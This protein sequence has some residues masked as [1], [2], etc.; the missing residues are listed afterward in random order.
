MNPTARTSWLAMIY[1][2]A[3]FTSAFLLFQIQPL[4]GK[5]ILPWFG[6]SPAVWT[7]CLLFFQTVLFAGYAYAHFSNSWLGVRQQ[8]MVHVLFVAAAATVALVHL[9]PAESWAPSG[10]IQ[11]IENILLL[12]GVSVGLPYFVLSATGPLLQAWFARSFPGQ[13]PYRLYA[14]SNFGSLLALVSY[15]FY[16]EP[17]YS[18]P[19]QSRIWAAGFVVYGLLCGLAAWRLW[20]A[21]TPMPSS[22]RRPNPRRAGHQKRGLRSAFPNRDDDKLSA[23]K[24]RVSEIPLH[25]AGIKTPALAKP[26]WLQ[27]FLWL[28][29][30]MFGSVMLLATTNLVTADIAVMPF[31]WIIPLA[32]YLLTFIIAFD[33][34]YWYHRAPIAALVLVSIYAA[35]LVHHE[36][37]GSAKLYELGTP[38]LIYSIF[39]GPESPQYQISSLAFLAVNILTLFAICMM[40]HGELV[41]QR[42]DP[43]YLTAYYLFIAAGGALGGVFVT[44]VAPRI[45]NNYYEWQ[46]CLILACLLAIGF[47]L[48]AIVDLAFGE[49]D[50]PR[51]I[52]HYVL[53][54][55]VVLG[56]FLP[57]A[58]MLLDLTE[59]LRP[60]SAA[61]LFRSRNFFGTLAVLERHQ[62]D[63]LK[64]NYYLR[65]GSITHGAQYTHP[66]R[67]QEP[68]TYYARTS[69]VARVIDFY[70]RQVQESHMRLGVVGLGT[71]TLAAF[72]DGGDAV[73]FYEINP[74]VV[75][76]AENGRWFTYLADCR[77]RGA[78]YEIRL[79]DA[80]LT[81]RREIAENRPQQYHVLVLDAFSSDAIPVHLL[82]VEAFEL[83]LAHLSGPLD[84]SDKVHSDDEANLHGAIAVHISNRYLDLSSVVFAVA[85]RYGL[86]AFRIENGDDS[87]NLTYSADWV[88]LS[89]NQQ[90]AEELRHFTS[91]PS[92]DAVSILWT[93]THSSLFDVLK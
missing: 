89:R 86:H 17:K 4:V 90:L 16:F 77:Q 64:H 66:L 70:R 82:T 74:D 21:A 19:L 36:G 57:S 12:L 73:V 65:H 83:Y 6:G 49:D 31:L 53:L 14:L 75:Q 55:I 51:Q 29:W 50:Q 91:P 33:R 37:V 88:I 84:N 23:A 40:C 72:A 87:K 59:F 46:L 20:A 5:H 18:L 78:H 27:G 34:P 92:P 54:G 30:P 93:D 7:T 8:A 85:Q 60:P 68:I 79:G 58:I 61:V 67:R 13:I 56:V 28:L 69:G 52:T 10:N 1:A 62:D 15:P 39:A 81:L 45:F 48:R 42:P 76:I 44:L 38:G 35:A 41:R 32:L 2:A 3:I 47:L 63:P 25:S 24:N 43:N 71:G 80:R 11:P 9:L 22:G 26:G